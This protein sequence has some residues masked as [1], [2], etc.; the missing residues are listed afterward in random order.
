MKNILIGG[1]SIRPVPKFGDY[2]QKFQP[3]TTITALLI[4]FV[5]ILSACGN[6]PA[7]LPEFEFEPE[8]RAS[9]DLQ[10]ALANLEKRSSYASVFRVDWEGLHSGVPVEGRLAL[11][12]V[13]FK[14]DGQEIYAIVSDDKLETRHIINFIQTREQTW[15]YHQ[16]Q[17]NIWQ[18]V[19]DNRL[20][21]LTDETFFTP[22]MF[23]KKLNVQVDAPTSPEPAKENG[24][25]AYRYSFDES[26]LTAEGMEINE[27]NGYA[28]V[29][30]EGGDLLTFYLNAEVTESLPHNVI[31]SGQMRVM[32]EVSPT[33]PDF[34]IEPPQ[35]TRNDIPLP[36]D[37]VLPDPT[38]IAIFRRST[39]TPQANKEIRFETSLDVPQTAHLYQTELPQHGWKA[40]S[41]DIP[42]DPTTTARLRYTKNAEG[43]E[44]T[45][46][47]E[48]G[49]ASVRINFESAASFQ[50]NVCGGFF[51]CGIPARIDFPLAPDANNIT[52]ISGM[53]AE[54]RLH[55]QTRAS[56]DDM[57]NFYTT[58]MPT[59][60]W[61]EARLADYIA[62]PNE[63]ALGYVKNNE[64]VVIYINNAHGITQVLITENPS[65]LTQW[66]DP[67]LQDLQMIR[68]FPTLPDAQIN[69]LLPGQ[70]TY[71]T[72]ED[73][74]TVVN[75][76]QTELTNEGWSLLPG[77]VQSDETIIA[78]YQQ[79][80]T[81]TT[82]M[83]KKE[84]AAGSTVWI[85]LFTKK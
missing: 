5:S 50:E 10:T 22:E 8:Q 79:D 37:V 82:V 75:F 72:T 64:P 78:R 59:E 23:L 1:T 40:F 19:S 49:G 80:T 53:G 11:E 9:F 48:D 55:Y 60:G 31:E 7:T 83:M 14:P 12:Q 63:T 44:I 77:K 42:F 21:I 41:Y 58:T 13:Q 36:S 18:E 85:T 15:F 6:T 30:A 26:N 67:N 24:V 54:D 68:N 29:S 65:A 16:G 46:I 66:I 81:T 69:R 33:P 17:S 35:T 43:I 73:I 2:L 3:T 27:A 28:Y 70:L 47:D 84:P 62:D 76:Y 20:E 61:T 52:F 57:V 38:P 25:L 56:M 51:R 45:V 74:N 39:P 32:F 71:Q 4:V 34:A